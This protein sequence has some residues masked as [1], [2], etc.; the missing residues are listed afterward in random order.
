MPFAD[1]HLHPDRN[2]RCVDAVIQAFHQ[3]LTAARRHWRQAPVIQS[4][5]QQSRFREMHAKDGQA[6]I[7]P[8]DF[9]LL[10]QPGPPPI[11]NA[12]PWRVPARCR[13]ASDPGFTPTR[14]ASDNQVLMLTNPEP[15]KK[16]VDGPSSSGKG[17]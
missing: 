11:Q 2:R 15:P 14:G 12:I 1:G 13:C 16:S 10:A 9:Q 4:S 5:S 17:S 7:L 6:A 3:I 8:C